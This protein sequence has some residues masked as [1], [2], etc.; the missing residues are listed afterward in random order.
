MVY[1]CSLH[2]SI[3]FLTNQNP[4]DERRRFA[5]PLIFFKSKGKPQVPQ[6]GDLLLRDRENH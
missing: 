6:A 5:P 3:K 1:I 4:K 2:R